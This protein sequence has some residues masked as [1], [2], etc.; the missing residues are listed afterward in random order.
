MNWIG[1]RLASADTPTGLST[2]Q[3]KTQTAL[4]STAERLGLP[5]FPRRSEGIADAEGMNLW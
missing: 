2:A 4:D 3:K 1:W 5:D